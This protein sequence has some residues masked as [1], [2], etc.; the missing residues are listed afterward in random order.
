MIRLNQLREQP[1][2]HLR[3]GQIGARLGVFIR[4]YCHHGSGSLAKTVA[5]HIEALLIHPDFDVPFEQRCAFR[6]L[7][8]HW[9]CLAWLDDRPRPAAAT[10]PGK[11]PGK[12]R[13]H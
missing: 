8:A 11:Q 5:D 6:H 2:N 4:M 1:L 10:E 7:Q 3:T 13:R 9:R 12:A